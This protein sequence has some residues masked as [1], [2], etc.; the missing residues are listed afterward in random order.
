MS[1]E[2]SNVTLNKFRSLA[3]Y[4]DNSGVYWH[5]LKAMCQNKFFN[6]ILL[7]NL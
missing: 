3:F 5:N 6:A 4:A 2:A 1:P 7:K